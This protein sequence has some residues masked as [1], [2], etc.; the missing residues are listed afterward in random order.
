MEARFVPLLWTGRELQLDVLIQSLLCESML[1]LGQVCKPSHKVEMQR[2]ET[3]MP[4]PL[5]IVMALEPG[6]RVD[7][8]PCK[9][10]WGGISHLTAMPTFEDISTL[11]LQCFVFKAGLWYSSSRSTTCVSTSLRPCQKTP[12]SRRGFPD[13]ERA[14]VAQPR[15][16]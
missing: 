8:S 5:A 12:S 6:S 7:L 9:D 16:N 10:D 11:V 3:S 14:L 4:C 1:G 2:S 13:Q 15:Q